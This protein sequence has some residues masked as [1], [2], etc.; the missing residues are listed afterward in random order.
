MGKA[1]VH[2]GQ[3]CW[4]CM[5]D[6]CFDEPTEHVWWDEDDVEHAQENGLPPPTGP[7]GCAWCGEPALQEVDDDA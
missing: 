4:P 5:T 6:C 7:C 3:R 1:C 2:Q